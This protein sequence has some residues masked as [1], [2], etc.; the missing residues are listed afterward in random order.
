MSA[1]ERRSGAR[2]GSLPIWP[3]L[4]YRGC[5]CESSIFGN[6]KRNE[7]ENE[8]FRINLI[9]ETSA[10]VLVKYSSESPRLILEW[11]Y[12]LDLYNQNITR[13]GAFNLERSSEVMDLREVDVLHI[14][15]AIIV[16]DLSA[17]PVDAFDLDDLAVFDLACK[18]NWRGRMS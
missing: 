14:I 7:L 3:L 1:P 6:E 17:G 18:G 4:C 2:D 5:Q 10:V 16:A 15:G 8:R 9:Q 13:L 12:F 11:L